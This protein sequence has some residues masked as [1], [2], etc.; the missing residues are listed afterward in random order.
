MSLAHLYI[1]SDGCPTDWLVEGQDETW[2]TIDNYDFQSNPEL[3]PQI[4][5]G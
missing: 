1:F 5:T 4:D 2:H 3:Q